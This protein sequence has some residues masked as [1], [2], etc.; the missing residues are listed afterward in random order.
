MRWGVDVK[1]SMSFFVCKNNI[2]D[3]LVVTGIVVFCVLVSKIIVYCF[4]K[5]V[6]FG[7][8]FLS[9]PV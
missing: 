7:Y 6:D 4:I 3:S 8:I 2:L 5:F 9:D 1:T